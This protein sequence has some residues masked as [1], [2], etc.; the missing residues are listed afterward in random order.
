M[1]ILPLPPL[2]PDRSLSWPLILVLACLGL[3]VL[4]A[5]D[6]GGARCP[7]DVSLEQCP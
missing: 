6:T 4:A 1:A 7:D 2:Q 3:A 5:I